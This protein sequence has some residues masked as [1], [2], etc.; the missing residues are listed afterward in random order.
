MVGSTDGT[1]DVILEYC[2]IIPKIISEQDMGVDDALNKGISV[3]SGD[4]IGF[5]R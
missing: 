3:A 5:L 4:I 2:E 1:K